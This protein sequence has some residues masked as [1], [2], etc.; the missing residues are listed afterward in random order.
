M[1]TLALF[2]V[3]MSAPFLHAK[4][5][6]GKAASGETAKPLLWSAPANISSRD[7]YFGIGGAQRAPKHPPFRFEKEDPSG[8]SPKFTV[9]DSQ[10]TKWK[11]KLGAEAR[12]ET[13]ATRLVW[14]VGYF[15]DEDYFVRSQKV[16]GMPRKLKRGSEQVTS[17][18]VVLDARWERIQEGKAGD[19]KWHK[20]P[21]SKTRELNG[22]RVLMA[23][24]NNYDMK[25]SQNVV[26][27]DDGSRRFAVADLGATLGPTGSHWPGHTRRGDLETYER[28]K[29]ITKVTP[30]H[31]DFAAPSWPMMFGVVP[32]VPLPYSVLT[33]PMRLFGHEPFPNEFT[34]RWIG[35]NIP[36]EDVRWIARLLEQLK[37]AQI[38]SA[39]RAAD[40]SPAEV[41][42]FSNVIENR[43]AQL[44]EL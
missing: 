15:T 41:E 29:F 38:R 36:R 9:V 28:S 23:L 4:A 24:L 14:S 2:C 31:I 3:F 34:E 30:D 27:N 8:N 39:F 7:L 44:S 20:N 26:Y 18:G 40:Y 32:M 33:S 43:I 21:F 1:R 17:D 22:L 19:W 5:K 16:E 42:A 25:D 13:V 11:V 37:P 10:G 35:R 6:P 12:P